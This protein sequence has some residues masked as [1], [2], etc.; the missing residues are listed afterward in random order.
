MSGFLQIGEVAT[1]TGLSIDAIRFYE[2]EGL[3]RTAVRSNGGFRLFSKPDVDDLAFIR[4]AQE[5]GFSLQEIRE[6]IGLKHTPHPDCQE[7]E[8]LLEKKI[9]LVREKIASLRKLERELQRA[10]ANCESNLRNASHGQ[11]EDCPVL[12]DIS[13]PKKRR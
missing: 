2:R 3:L 10:M 12:S 5:L 9:V 8:H 6:L 7:V 11:A 4:N 1:Q 13:Q